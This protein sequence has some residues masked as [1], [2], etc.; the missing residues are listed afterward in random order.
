[1]SLPPVSAVATS[2]PLGLK[3]IDEGSTRVPGAGTEVNPGVTAAAAWAA[4]SETA[5]TSRA[6]KSLRITENPLSV[7]RTGSVVVRTQKPNAQDEVAEGC[8]VAVRRR[9]RCYMGVGRADH[10]DPTGRSAVYLSGL[11]ICPP[12]P[13]RRL[14][15]PAELLSCF[16][17][18]DVTR[19]IGG[20][21]G[22][23]S[24]THPSPAV[25]AR[26]AAQDTV[27]LRASPGARL[28]PSLSQEVTVSRRIRSSRKGGRTS[29][30]GATISGARVVA[31]RLVGPSAMGPLS[32]AVSAVGALAIGRL[33]IANA[34][35][36]KLSAGEVEIGA[37]RV[38]ELEVGG[39]RWPEPG[40]G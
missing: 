38:R 21:A 14:A 39:R 40:S 12:R 31:A 11:P 3:A 27:P 32:I 2:A 36:R 17:A 37:L 26:S 35:I 16:Q 15:L 33:A 23:C 10:P 34:V 30:D 8:N 13:R 1:M 6:A 24:L 5:V 7:E 28:Y 20:C 9:T 18:T 22:E 25:C 29:V 4:T 19:K